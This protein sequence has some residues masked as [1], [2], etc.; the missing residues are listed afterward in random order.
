MIRRP[1][2]S[3]LFPYTTLFRSR[4]CALP[5]ALEPGVGYEQLLG[6]D[7]L[8]VE[9]HGDLE[10]AARARHRAHHPAPELAVSH[11]LTGRVARRVLRSLDLPIQ[12]RQRRALHATTAR[13]AAH[14]ACAGVPQRRRAPLFERARRQSLEEARRLRQLEAPG[15]V[16]RARP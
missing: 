8:I 11:P 16:P 6:P 12:L 9:F 5:L 3:T 7:L 10:L 15:A 1:P 14:A 4:S 13:R 2:R